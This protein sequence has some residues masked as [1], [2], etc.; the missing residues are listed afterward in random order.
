MKNSMAAKST[1]YQWRRSS[2][3]IMLNMFSSLLNSE[4]TD[5]VVLLPVYWKYTES[6]ILAATH[7]ELTMTKSQRH[8]FCHVSFSFACI[9]KSMK[10]MYSRLVYSMAEVSNLHEPKTMSIQ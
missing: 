1:R 9:G 8:T 4:N 5:V 6:M 2:A 7:R 10:R 3:S